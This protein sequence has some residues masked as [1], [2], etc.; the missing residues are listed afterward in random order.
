M[1][2]PVLP[3]KRPPIKLERNALGLQNIDGFQALPRLEPRFI[4]LQLG[5]QVVVRF[6]RR[7]DP[8]TGRM[9]RMGFGG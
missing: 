5:M 4:N 2:S 7:W 6:Q 8:L 3:N 9:G 1:N